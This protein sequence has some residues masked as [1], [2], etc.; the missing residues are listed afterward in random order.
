MNK[1][2]LAA[3]L[4]STATCHAAAPPIPTTSEP[5]RTLPGSYACLVRQGKNVYFFSEQVDNGQ[6]N[7]SGK[8]CPGITLY[9]AEGRDFTRAGFLKTVAPNKLIND[10]YLDPAH[11]DPEKL[12]PDRL[13]TRL[14]VAWSETDRKFYAIGYVSRGY[15]SPDHQVVPA[16][17]ESENDDPRG[18]WTYRGRITPSNQLVKDHCSGANLIINENH[19]RTVNHES[20]LENKFVHYIEM[21]KI[22]LLYSNDGRE[23]FLRKDDDGN[24]ANIQPPELRS[25]VPW[26]FPSV[27]RTKK[28]GLFMF[29]TI[30]WPPRGHRLLHSEDGLT[31]KVISGEKLLTNV[32]GLPKAKNVSL[33]YDDSTD[34]L[35]LLITRTGSEHFK[36]I[37]ARKPSE[38]YE[39]QES[40]E[41]TSP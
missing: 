39:N 27:V 33:S 16:L 4:T 20:P 40:A 3:V 24:I 32:G 30:G 36:N 15:P 11:P 6:P 35:Y 26:I 8:I 9:S 1:A 19:G 34:M 21:G 31:W 22:A 14:G 17:F 2:I 18:R 41:T 25:E 28:D 7:A 10:V 29:I 5:V 13:I 12:D 38:L 37:L 23:W